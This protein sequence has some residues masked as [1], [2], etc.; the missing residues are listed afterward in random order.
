MEKY[1]GWGLGWLA[2]AVY[3]VFRCAALLLGCLGKVYSHCRA[4]MAKHWETLDQ[5]LATFLPYWVAKRWKIWSPVLIGT[6]TAKEVPA[7]AV[8]TPFSGQGAMSYVV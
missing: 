5:T 4:K 7:I 2:L 1:R 3:G 6:L 8:S